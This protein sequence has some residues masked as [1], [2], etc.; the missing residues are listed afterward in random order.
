LTRAKRRPDGKQIAAV[1]NPRTSEF[2]DP[3]TQLDPEQGPRL[4]AWDVDTRKQRFSVDL[5]LGKENWGQLRGY[6]PDGSTLVVLPYSLSPTKDSPV[7]FYDAATGQE[8]RSIHL[9]GHLRAMAVDFVRK[10]IIAV[11][12]RVELNERFTSYGLADIVVFDLE[13]LQ[14][15]T[16]LRGHGGFDYF[17]M[18]ADGRRI[19]LGNTFAKLHA[20]SRTTVRSSSPRTSS[21]LSASVA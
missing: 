12:K 17:D 3:A 6:S 2:L 21:T 9:P 20:L 16:R 4:L 15:R 18:T 13:T 19:I 11:G 1:I 8:R 10:A 5:Q 7:V 14:E